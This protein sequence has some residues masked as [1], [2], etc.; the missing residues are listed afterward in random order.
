MGKQDIEEI[1]SIINHYMT[2][3]VIKTS[4][5]PVFVRDMAINKMIR[6]R[7]LID[8]IDSEN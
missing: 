1:K 7:I 5:N 6:I 2:N 4:E 8:R 3:E